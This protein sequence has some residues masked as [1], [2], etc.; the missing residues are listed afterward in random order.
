MLKRKS[1]KKVRG[2]KQPQK[3]E[4]PKKFSDRRFLWNEGG[5]AEPEAV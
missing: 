1:K 4:E 3:K 2:N 5:G